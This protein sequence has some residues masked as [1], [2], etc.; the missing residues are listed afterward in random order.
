LDEEGLCPA[1]DGL[2]WGGLSDQLPGDINLITGLPDDED[3]EI[4]P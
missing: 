3:E 2:E 4:N 1:C